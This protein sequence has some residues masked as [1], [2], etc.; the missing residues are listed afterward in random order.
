V[1][2]Q[3]TIRVTLKMGAARS[4]E[5]LVIYIHHYAVSEEREVK[6]VAERNSSL[7]YFPLNQVEIF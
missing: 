7:E 4:S 3:F 5:T 2:L 1:T 6:F